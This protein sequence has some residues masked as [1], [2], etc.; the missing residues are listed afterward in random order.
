LPATLLHPT[1]ARRRFNTASVTDDLVERDDVHASQNMKL[2]PSEHVITLN[3][4]ISKTKLFHIAMKDDS[5]SRFPINYII[6][7]SYSVDNELF[8]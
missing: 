6:K 3:K 7:K 4:A 2:E 1:T 5:P 8:F